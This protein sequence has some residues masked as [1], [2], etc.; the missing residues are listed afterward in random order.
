MMHGRY[1]LMTMPCHAVV[2]IN[3]VFDR[4]IAML[5]ASSGPHVT[6]TLDLGCSGFVAGKG[7]LPH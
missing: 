6:V 1:L 4:V 3:S 5:R 2:V 7:L